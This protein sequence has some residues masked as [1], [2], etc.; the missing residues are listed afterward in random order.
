MAAIEEDKVL[1]N[2]RREAIWILGIWILATAYCCVFSYY[3]GYIRK[4]HEL[5][6]ADVHPT[7]GMPW[8]FAWGVLVPWGV[9]GLF[10][11]WFV[12]FRM[13]EDD[14]GKDHVDPGDRE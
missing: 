14:L 5:T 2:S 11:F 12:I 6:G 1:V 3:F 8:W 9:C 13:A 7:L 10:T 4:D